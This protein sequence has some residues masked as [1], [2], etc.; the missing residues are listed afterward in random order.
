[1]TGLYAVDYKLANRRHFHEP[2]NGASVKRRQ[3]RVANIALLERQ[4]K[5]ENTVFELRLKAQ[6]CSIGNIR[7]RLRDT[8][9]NKVW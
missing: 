1:M 7:Q 5:R 9:C 8:R 6:F 4:N 3:D 2:A